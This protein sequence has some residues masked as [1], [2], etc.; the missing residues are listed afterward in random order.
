MGSQRMPLLLVWDHNPRTAGLKC[1]IARPAS[2][3]VCCHLNQPIISLAFWWG[4]SFF[5]APP[6][7]TP[8]VAFNANGSS[9]QL[10]DSGL[11]LDSAPASSRDLPWPLSLWVSTPTLWGQARSWECSTQ[12]VPCCP[13]LVPGSGALVTGKLTL[14]SLSVLAFEKTNSSQGTLTIFAKF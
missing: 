13:L 5:P 4:L 3:S 7:L 12:A 11:G 6:T 2:S 9:P 8:G 10:Q 14:W 1:E